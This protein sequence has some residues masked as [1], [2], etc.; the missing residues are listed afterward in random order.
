MEKCECET[1]VAC[2]GQAWSI[3]LQRIF[4]RALCFHS[5]PQAHIAIQYSFLLADRANSNFQQVACQVIQVRAIYIFIV[6]TPSSRIIHL[7]ESSLDKYD[8][9]L[10]SALKFSIPFHSARPCTIDQIMA[11][12]ESL[13]KFRLCGARD[14]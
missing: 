2:K 11:R 5:K 8:L 7:A 14:G 13:F 1:N 3:Q 10:S 4:T 12:M 9:I 6:V